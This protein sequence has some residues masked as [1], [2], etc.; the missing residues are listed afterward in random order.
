M[1]LPDNAMKLLLFT[2]GVLVAPAVVFAGPEVRGLW[3]VR[4]A[5]VSPRAVD[6][7]VDRAAEGGFNTLVVQVRGRGDAFY[8]SRLVPRSVL[9]ER[10]TRDFDPF[11]RLIERARLRGLQ[12]HAW[13]NVLLTAH[14]GQPM[15]AGH[16]LRVHPNWVMAP[17]SLGRAVLTAPPSSLLALV[18]AASRGEGDA[19]GYYLSPAAPGVS[20]H[21]EAVVRELLRAYPV[22]GLHLDFIRYPGPEYDYS[23]AAL[24]GFHRMQGAG[25][26][27]L[28]APLREPSAW[29]D[30]RRNLLNALAARLVG[31]ARA[32][33]PGAVVSAAVVPDEAQAIHHKFQAWPDWVAKGLL[34]AVCPMTYSEDERTFRRQLEQARTRVGAGQALWAGVGAYRLPLEDV[35]GRVKAA[36]EL[37][38]AGVLVFSNESLSPSDFPRLRR[39]AFP[40]ERALDTAGAA[41]KRGVGTARE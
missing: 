31:A 4:T 11:A 5:L 36:R 38:A 32:E 20:R 28:S 37:G 29:S 27:V 17:R 7:V 19:E 6:E 18:R 40:G 15:P 2:L 25:T 12:V 1:R 24:E 33:R 14:F 23:A 10:Q 39:E 9:L 41:P 35:I 34:D 16:V 22:Q 3:V 8:A 30:Y 21:L 13:V 26:D